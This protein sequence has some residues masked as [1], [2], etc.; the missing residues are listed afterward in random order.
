[1]NHEYGVKASRTFPT[2]C[3][4]IAVHVQSE[5]KRNTRKTFP[6]NR[7][8]CHKYEITHQRFFAVISRLYIVSVLSLKIQWGFSI[9]FTR[10]ARGYHQ[11][12][13]VFHEFVKSDYEY[14]R[15]RAHFIVQ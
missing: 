4:I 5:T 6:S 10:P 12:S 3:G 1:M 15:L 7:N 8:N 13:R 14:S 9:F 2:V 11:L